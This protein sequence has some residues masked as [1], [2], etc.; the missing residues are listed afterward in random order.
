MTKKI[1]L[2]AVASE[3]GHLIQLLRLE[4]MFKQHQSILVSTNKEFKAPDCFE[5]HFIT[6]DINQFSGLLAKISILFRT[7]YLIIKIKPDVI[8]STG[9]LPGLVAIII[10]KVI[11]RKKTIW[12]DSIANGH[13]LSKSGRAA[14]RF[15]DIWLTQWSNLEEP[16][17]PNFLGTVI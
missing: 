3:G 9:A 17:G 4:T 14:G 7:L 8:I 5:D 2:M 16:T 1:K 13:E 12:L 6:N 10:G 15:C 11:F